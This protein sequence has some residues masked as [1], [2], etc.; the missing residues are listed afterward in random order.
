LLSRKQHVFSCSVSPERCFLLLSQLTPLA[1]CS[2]GHPETGEAFGI[3]SRDA[4]DA[5]CL[6]TAAEFALCEAT[7][8]C[9]FSALGLCLKSHEV[10]EGQN[11]IL[12][13][14]LRK[15]KKQLAKYVQL[16]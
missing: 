6:E 15:D 3:T 16:Q 1:A 14:G 5:P 2:L 13:P 9:C 4:G 10:T 12:R 7:G 11:V 8:K